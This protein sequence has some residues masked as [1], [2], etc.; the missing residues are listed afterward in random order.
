MCKVPLTYEQC[1]F[2]TEHHGLVYKFLNENRLTAD[3]FYDIVIFGYLKAVQIYFSNPELQKY[4]FATIA[5]RKM[6]GY[7]KNHLR[8][9]NRRKRSAEIVSIHV[10]MNDTSLPLEQT[11]SKPDDWMLQLETKL[12]LHDLAGRI[13]HQQMDMVRMKSYGYGIRDI[14]RSQK[15]PMKR[16]KETLEDVRQILMELCCE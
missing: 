8:T 12:L 11:L 15:V 4:S 5:W 1:L 16:V 14:A 7:L 3:D 2:A 6:D 13:S 9:Q 10:G